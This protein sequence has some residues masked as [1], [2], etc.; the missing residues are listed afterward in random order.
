MKE[1][2]FLSISRSHPIAM[3]SY[4]IAATELVILDF[5][6]VGVSFS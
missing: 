4:K 5:R 1:A 3:P 2:S 6:F